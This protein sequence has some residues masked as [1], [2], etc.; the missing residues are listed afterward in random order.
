MDIVKDES[1]WKR[2]FLDRF[3]LCALLCLSVLVNVFLARQ[4]ETSRKSLEGPAVLEV[5]SNVPPIT[6][7][8][9]SGV[10]S[11]LQYN[12]T[13]LPTVLYVFTPQC[14][15][16]KKNVNN[17]KEMIKGSGSRYRV[18]GISLTTE[19]LKD[20]VSKN[21]LNFPVLS[22]LNDATVKTYKL[23]G[24][25]TTIVVSPASKV[26]KV[27]SGV[28]RERNLQE[29]NRFLGVQLPGCCSE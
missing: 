5:G 10:E 9:V 13:N 4:L 26:L 8:L 2:G 22:D 16:C 3:T 12:D 29:I 7:R 21:E 20:Y 6:G 23:Y 18:V 15:W 28:Y 24:T 27:W 19:D 25:P 1:R 17:L 11:K 14:G